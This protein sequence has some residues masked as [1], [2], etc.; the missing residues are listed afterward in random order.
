MERTRDDRRTR[1]FHR[2]QGRR[3]RCRADRGRRR[4][5]PEQPPMTDDVSGLPDEPSDDLGDFA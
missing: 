1:E 3:R 5:A 2:R 4:R